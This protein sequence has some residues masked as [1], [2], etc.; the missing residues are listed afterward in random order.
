MVSDRSLDFFLLLGSDLGQDI[1]LAWLQIYHLASPWPI[2][3]FA[4]LPHQGIQLQIQGK[5][6]V[7]CITSARNVSSSREKL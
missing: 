3:L 4:Y 5:G 6:L 7:R 1:L 2:L